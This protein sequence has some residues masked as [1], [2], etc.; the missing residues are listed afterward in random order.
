MIDSFI[1]EGVYSPEEIAI[2]IEKTFPA[3]KNAEERVQEHIEHLQT[4]DA[5][6]QVS[7]T[8]PHY[9]KITADLA[10]NIRVDIT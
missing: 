8:K 9:L 3:V 7:G 5:R 1:L 4:S 10:R 6:G 2:I